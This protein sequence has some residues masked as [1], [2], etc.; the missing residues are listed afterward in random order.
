M[1][2]VLFTVL[3]LTLSTAVCAQP[4]TRFDSSA[5][6]RI[7]YE[8]L[9]RY[10][11]DRATLLTGDR[12]SVSFN[13]IKLTNL[14]SDQTLRGV[15][16]NISKKETQ[17]MGGSIALAAVGG[18]FGASSSVTY[19]RIR[20]SGY[21]FLRPK[22]VSEVLKFLESVIGNIGR[23]QPNRFQI[24]K[25]SIQDGFELGMMYDPEKPE[26]GKGTSPSNRPRWTFIVTASGATYELDY[27]QGLDLVR[28]FSDWNDQ[29][30][31]SGS[32]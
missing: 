6:S 13:F 9:D 30:S 8:R 16:V 15:E 11:Q 12:A 21:I 20:D 26:T 10:E 25:I 7:Q 14:T 29:L 24:W 3:T 28:R 19:R 27:A 22:D 1:R 18:M 31:A 4:E 17:S 32:K 23:K 2:T 5:I